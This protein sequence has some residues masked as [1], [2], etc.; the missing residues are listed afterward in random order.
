MKRA[1]EMTGSFYELIGSRAFQRQV[2]LAV[3]KC[4]LLALDR[5]W[6]RAGQQFRF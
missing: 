6:S 1:S 2:W 4:P 5:A 3:P